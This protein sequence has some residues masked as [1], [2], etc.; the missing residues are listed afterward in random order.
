M[1]QR[2]I[3]SP[4]LGYVLQP[5]TIF[6][7]LA[8]WRLEK[9]CFGSDDAYSLDTILTLMLTPHTIRIKAVCDDKMVGFVAGEIDKYQNMGWIITIGVLPEFEG[10]GIG[11]SL[12]ETAEQELWHRTSAIR[13]T[14][15]R[16]NQRA[17]QLY[18][19]TGYV[20]VSTYHR[21]YRDGE[22]GLVMEKNLTTLRYNL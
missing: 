4:E 17:I 14:V 1:A 8:I 7:L 16:S 12:L 18:Q 20:W 11:K 10:R 22:D 3:A 6:D 19:H 2:A 5:V 9:A 21:Y 13:L 15:R